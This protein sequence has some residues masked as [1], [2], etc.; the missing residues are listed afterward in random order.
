[1]SKPKNNVTMTPRNKEGTM[2]D[3]WYT[4]RN[5]ER[6]RLIASTTT[7][8]KGVMQLRRT[9]NVTDIEALPSP[10]AKDDI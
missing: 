5:G 4:G 7:I 6:I 1:M 2:Y 8:L 3:I 9:V 10:E